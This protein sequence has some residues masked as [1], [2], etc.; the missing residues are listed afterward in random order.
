MPHTKRK[1]TVSNSRKSSIQTLHMDLKHSTTQ[2]TFKSISPGLP[3]HIK[4]TKNE[5][6]DINSS[7][8]ALFRI[9]LPGSHERHAQMGVKLMTKFRLAL[10]TTIVVFCRLCANPLGYRLGHCRSHSTLDSSLIFK[11]PRRCLK[12]F[13]MVQPPSFVPDLFT[14][15]LGNSQR[16]QTI[17]QQLCHIHL[18]KVFLE[19]L[20]L[21]GV[22][23]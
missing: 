19:Y 18:S 12:R 22:F 1:N 6:K 8:F 17:I 20:L 7:T 23:P 16:E 10:G 4:E 14:C 21:S 3:R 15:L 2:Y 5:E 9:Q 13:S 11:N